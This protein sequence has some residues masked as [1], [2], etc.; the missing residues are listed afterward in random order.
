MK[1][2]NHWIIAL[3]ISS[4]FLSAAFSVVAETIS[5]GTGDVSQIDYMTGETK[6]VTHSS[7][8]D[9]N[10]LDITQATYTLQGA[11]ATLT[12]DVSGVIENR[13]EILDPNSANFPETI[14]AVEYLFELSTSGEDYSVS[15]SN[16]TGQLTSGSSDPVNLTASDFSIVGGTL[17][18]SF[19]LTSADENYTSLSVTTTYIKADLSSIEAGMIYLSDVAPNPPLEVAEAFAYDTGSVGESIQFNA[20]IS[21]L[22]GAPPY[23]YHWDFGDQS[24]STDLNP[25]H[26]FTKTGKYTYNFTV[27]DNNDATAFQTGTI[28]ITQ[29]GGG[30]GLSTQMILFLAVLLIIVVIG[31]VIIIWIIKRR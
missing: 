16:G 22:T 17:S 24:T 19:S 27:T 18:V 2:Q 25:V 12:L 13:G 31:V 21:P 6:I 23:T 8:I 20:T 1:I 15:Y 14:D 26:T 3:I 28:T 29:E 9:V 11:R 5:D 7:Y 30:G 4:L 10:N